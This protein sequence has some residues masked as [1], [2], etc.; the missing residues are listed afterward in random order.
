MWVEHREALEAKRLELF[1]DLAQ[2]PALAPEPPEGWKRQ[3][4]ARADIEQAVKDVAGQVWALDRSPETAA[5][6]QWLL[7]TY[8]KTERGVVFGRNF[9]HHGAGRI[10]VGDTVTAADA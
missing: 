7:A 9:N 3:L 8:R 4:A 5:E 10:T 2:T 1:P 6:A